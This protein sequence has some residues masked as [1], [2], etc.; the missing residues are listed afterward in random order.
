MGKAWERY[1][2]GMGKVWERYGKGMGK[3]SLA[4]FKDC[5][6]IRHCE[7]PDKDASY[8]ERTS[9]GFSWQSLS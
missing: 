3:I 7:N 6:S 4:P 8:L 9:K 2:Q 5:K 1:G